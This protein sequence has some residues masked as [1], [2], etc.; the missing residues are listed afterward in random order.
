MFLIIIYFSDAINAHHSEFRMHIGNGGSFCWATS[1]KLYSLKSYLKYTG[2]SSDEL[3]GE[4]LNGAYINFIADLTDLPPDTP[5][6][7]MEPVEPGSYLLRVG[8]KYCILTI[9]Y[10]TPGYNADFVIKFV[11]G[12][13]SRLD[14]PA[15]GR[16]IT[17][18]ATYNWTEYM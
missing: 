2:I 11:G 17:I 8:D 15:Y 16:P 7:N 13:F 6:P 10:F 4:I 14:D 12:I 18:S 3:R 5:N 9:P 1:V